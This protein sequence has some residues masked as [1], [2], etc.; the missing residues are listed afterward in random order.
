MVRLVAL[1]CA[2][3]VAG[4]L[5]VRGTLAYGGCTSLFES[6]AGSPCDQAGACGAGNEGSVACRQLVAGYCAGVGLDR[7]VNRGCSNLGDTSGYLLPTASP[8]AAPSVDHRLP[9]AHQ[10]NSAT[11]AK[12]HA[13][14]VAWAAVAAG[15][16]AAAAGG[17]I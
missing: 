4:A 2:L 13:A 1:L 6:V 7:D 10:L 17:M 3:F 12:G 11:V 9:E 14:H 5:A 8:S 16:L 15:L